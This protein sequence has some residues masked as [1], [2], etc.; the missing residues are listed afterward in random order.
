MASD[1]TDTTLEE[2]DASADEKKQLRT[3]ITWLRSDGEWLTT[4]LTGRDELVVGRDADCEVTLEG[5]LTSRRHARLRRTGSSWFVEDLESRNGITLNGEAIRQ[6]PLT[7]GDVLRIGTFI[8]MVLRF[9]PGE[10]PV[11]EPLDDNLFGGPDLRGLLRQLEVAG[12]S[13]LPTVIE[14]ATGTGKEQFARAI[15]RRSGRTGAFLAINAAVYQPATAAAELFG[16]RKGAFTGA[17]RANPGLIRA[18]E[19][20]TLLLDEITDL[21]LE[22][23]AQLLRAIENR[24]LI[25]LGES[26]TI[27]VNVRF[28]A[29]T[30]EPLSVAVEAGRFRTDLRARLEGLR[31]VMPELAARR[32]DVP[33]LFLHLLRAH[34]PGEPPVPDARVLERLYLYGWPLNVREMVSLVKRLVSAYPDAETLSLSQVTSQFP[35]LDAPS[36]TNASSKTTGPDSRATERRH[37]ADPRAFRPEELSELRAALERHRGNVA[38]AA[39][40]LGISRQRAYRMLKSASS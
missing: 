37:R 31:I 1:S 11:Y 33:F 24:E 27:S 3:A 4:W 8:G 10:E 26:Q 28:L 15:H 39:A 7:S 16:Y 18:A 9:G 30:Q 25:P 23:Q 6:A 19:G 12:T 20:G 21:S 29:A 13:D 38:S 22:V 5:A 34:S 40:E 32:G 35:E 36:R 2:S 17:E 14:G